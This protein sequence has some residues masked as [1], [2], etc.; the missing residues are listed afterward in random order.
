MAPGLPSFALFPLADLR[1]QLSI[2]EW[3][4]SLDAWLVLVDS[5]LTLSQ[6]DF[7]NISVKDESLAAFLVLFVKEVAFNGAGILGKSPSAKKL[8]TNSFQLTCRLLESPSPPTGLAEWGFLADVGRVYGKKRTGALL[9]SLSKAAQTQLD[10]SLADLKKTLIKDLDSGISGG[11]L[12]FIEETLDRLNNLINASP[13]IAEFFLAGSDFMDGLITCYKI[14]NPPLRKV[15]LSTTYLSLVTL[16]EGQKASALT[17][18]LYS[19]KAAATAHKSGPLNANDSLV[20]ELVTSTPLLSHLTARLTSPTTRTT[21]IITDLS[22]FRKPQPSFPRPKRAPRPSK[23]KA[24]ETTADLHIHHATSIIQIQD[25]F[26][27]LGTAYILHLLTHYTTPESVISH[28]LDNDLAPELASLDQT[29]N[30]P[31]H[32]P[33]SPRPTP[34]LPTDDLDLDIDV[35]RLHVGKAESTTAL[36]PQPAPA[37]AAILSA[38]LAFDSDDDERDDTYD[39]ADVGGTVD[40][41]GG[42]DDT[43]LTEG[44]EAILF[45]KWSVTPGLFARDAATR[46]NGERLKLRTETGMT[47]EQIE[48]WGIMVGRDGRMQ[49]RL[50]AR[51]GEWSGEQAELESTSWREGEEGEDGGQGSYRGGRG[52]GRGG[53]GRGR[54]RGGAPVSEDVARRRKEANKG[55]RA[56]HNRRDQRA[57]KMARGGMTG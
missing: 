12:R 41:A 33:L 49:K 18:H 39:A 19:L 48:G 7:R 9:G 42:E 1:D 40:A 44:V 32:K 10:S 17:D 21:S 14:M 26:P 16:A 30:I 27:H 11:K 6:T 38:L 29:A 46:K 28:L 8:L 47:D 45:K 15:I 57:R 34:P 53:Q 3:V 23:G 35:S 55:S 51:F 43:P 22:S 52:R 5:H 37:K 25:L 54:G 24:P 56:N 4:G 31:L 2:D 50:A 13:S 36:A 20:A